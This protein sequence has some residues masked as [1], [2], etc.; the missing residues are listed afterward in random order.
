[1][2]T[3]TNPFPSRRTVLAS[4]GASLLPSRLFAAPA[5]K[6]K[7]IVVG[8]PTA[9]LVAQQ[10]FADGGNVFDAVVAGALAAAMTVPYQFGIGGY[11]GCATLMAAGC[12]QV[13]SVDFNTIAPDA[14]RPDIFK[15]DRVK[16]NTVNTHGWLA[17]GAPGI[18]A[19]LQHLLDKYGT[20]KFEQVVQPA[21]RLAREGVKVE[22][23]LASTINVSATQFA[24]DAGSK[25]L[26]F[27][28]GKPLKTGDVLKNPDLADMLTTLAKRGSVESFYK[29]DIAEQIADCFKKNG[30]LITAKDM[31]ACKAREV[32][33]LEWSSEGMTVHTAPLTAGG[34]TTLQALRIVEQ[35]TLKKLEAD[36][37]A[38]QARIEAL[39]LA[40]R[41]RLKLLGDPEAGKIPVDRLMS[42]EYAVES[43]YVI[44]AILKN[45]MI[46]MHNV[47][48]RDQPGTISLSG[49]DD[50]GNFIAVTISHGDSFGARV[51]VE[52]LGLTLGHGMS[53]FDTDPGHPNAPG[54]G[55]R[56][57]NNMCPTIVTRDNK[58]LLAIGGRGG[59]KI[60]NALFE[61][62]TQFV[63]LGR[64]LK[65]S[66]AAPRMHTE[67]T[68]ALTLE[69]HWNA[70]EA[71]ELGKR[72]Y[73]V[74]TGASAILSAVWPENAG[75]VGEMR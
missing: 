53:R 5:A 72:G 51:T 68:P 49:G 13:V 7:G 67:G 45:K 31:A 71:K 40:W 62:L 8:D 21:I 43:A 47:T 17:S 55:K 16:P 69:K 4:V 26:Y 52:G 60:P 38:T 3:P 42:K 75:V 54:P 57:L 28:N 44:N 12:K 15:A 64:T 35:F 18:L 6:T 74:T 2:T 63:I 25:K 50:L 19:G 33:P 61:A 10:I 1:M 58:P 30:G 24:L 34:L 70:D 22:G 56:P 14:M 29:G 59:R 66:M 20:L 46:L 23:A 9:S 39:R 11:G 37:A 73:K 32:K 48:P 41:D 27:Q 65:Q 36:V